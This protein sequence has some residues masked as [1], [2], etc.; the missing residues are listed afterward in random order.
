ML[1]PNLPI[2]RHLVDLPGLYV[3]NLAHSPRI[4]LMLAAVFALVGQFETPKLT[5]AEERAAS[6]VRREGGEIKWVRE[7][8]EMVISVDF[9]PSSRPLDISICLPL[10]RLYAIRVLRR[11]VQKKSLASL[12]NLEGLGL[13]V[14]ITSSRGLDDEDLGKIAKCHRLEKLDVMGDG[15]THVGLASIH[16]MVKLRR[17]YL[18]NTK[19]TDRDIQPLTKMS[20]LQTLVLPKTVSP[21]GIDAL[22]SRLKGTEVTRI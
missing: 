9:G 21:S 22:K 5:P 7:S 17:L 12:S 2:I 16:K 10:R 4:Q 8:G 18:Y 11:D 1:T 20:W 13:L 15:I 19:L 6:S 14:I 3:Y